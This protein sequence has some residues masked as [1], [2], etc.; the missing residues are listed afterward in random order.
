MPHL[1]RLLIALTSVLWSLC[2]THLSYAD[3][4]SGIQLFS[5][6]KRYQ[7]FES[8]FIRNAPAGSGDLRTAICNDNCWSKIVTDSTSGAGFGVIL[9]NVHGDVTKTALQTLLSRECLDALIDADVAQDSGEAFKVETNH[10]DNDKVCESYSKVRER[11]AAIPSATGVHGKLKLFGA[12]LHAIQD[13]YSHSN[14]LELSLAKDEEQSP[15]D[16][17][18]FDFERYCPKRGNYN[19]LGE[20]FT[21]FYEGDHGP[22]GILVSAEDYANP[23]S[24]LHWNKDFSPAHDGF[25]AE[26]YG[27]SSLKRSKHGKGTAYFDFV[28]DL[29]VRNTHLLYKDVLS[30]LPGFDK[31]CRLK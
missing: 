5:Y 12:V 29:Q 10:F 11:I 31:S 15:G 24:H 3:Q 8:N 7:D 20:V 6:E 1:Y 28:F 26:K 13:F 4:V 9:A 25:W 21:G 17:S 23:R 2:R 27:R 18:L 22:K 14:Y 16:L 19:G 30:R